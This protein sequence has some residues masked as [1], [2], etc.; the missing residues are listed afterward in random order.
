MYACIVCGEELFSSDT[1]YD[2]GCGWP[3]FYDITDNKK[4][5]LKPDLSH[6]KYRYKRKVIVNSLLNMCN[7]I[8]DWF[9]KA[10]SKES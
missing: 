7:I 3:A 10:I 4:I 8:I 9:L 1:K 2:S 6:S 5:S